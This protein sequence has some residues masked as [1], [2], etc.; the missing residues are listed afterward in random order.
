MVQVIGSD[1]VKMTEVYG[2]RHTGR[3]W[4]AWWDCVEAEHGRVWACPQNMNS[5]EINDKGQSRWQPANQDHTE[6]WLLKWCAGAFVYS[7]RY[8]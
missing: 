5:L 7:F 1:V 3:P 4:K 6:K 8:H 2:T